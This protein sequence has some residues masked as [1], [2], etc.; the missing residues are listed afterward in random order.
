MLL[1]FLPEVAMLISEVAILRLDSIVTDL[2]MLLYSEV[3]FFLALCWKSERRVTLRVT[4]SHNPSH[5]GP[6]KN[7][8]LTGQ[9][10]S[11]TKTALLWAWLLPYRETYI[12]GETHCFAQFPFEAQ[13]IEQKFMAKLYSS[14]DQWRLGSISKYIKLAL[15]L[16]IEMKKLLISNFSIVQTPFPTSKV[17]KKKLKYVCK[18]S[19]YWRNYWKQGCQLGLQF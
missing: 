6:I 5:W 12:H 17:I 16:H 13:L 15:H 7:Q 18:I 19:L 1:Q 9:S 14:V 4:L 10:A 11:T 2:M 3:P 8:G